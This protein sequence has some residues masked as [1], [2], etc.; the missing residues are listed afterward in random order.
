M[1]YREWEPP[2]DLKDV[3]KCFWH[4][5]KTYGEGAEG[6]ETVWPDGRV[7]VLFTFGARYRVASDGDRVLPAFFVIGPLT[8]PV[9]LQ[10]NGRLRLYGI[11]LQAWGFARLFP[12]S[13][14]R[15]KDALLPLAAFADKEAGKL[16][17]DLESGP[18][19]EAQECLAGWVRERLQSNARPRDKQLAEL[20]A[21]LEKPTGGLTIQ[22][23]A[24]NAGWSI[25][26]LERKFQEEIGLPPKQLWQIYRF[27]E[28]RQ[29]LFFHP[30]TELMEVA[31]RCGYYDY[32]HFSKAFVRYFG[33][34]PKSFQRRFRNR[35]DGRLADPE[36]VVFVQD[37]EPADRT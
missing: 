10:A 17:S 20:A 26:Q 12:V 34:T 1:S 30:E 2:E 22:E 8:R 14:R 29:T 19:E 4:M 16:A 21:F 6:S 33:M 15:L 9:E 25:R 3:V 31:Y 24:E 35:R 28:A 5:D 32:P 37:F 11:R 18:R 7:E 27:N 36:D 13:M 23:W